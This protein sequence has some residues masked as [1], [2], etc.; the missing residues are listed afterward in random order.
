MPYVYV[1]S[2]KVEVTKN[3]YGVLKRLRYSD[4]P[5]TLWVDALCINQADTTEKS[6]QVLLMSEIY[7]STW[8]CLI[9]LG[10]EPETPVST[11]TQAQSQKVE[12]IIAET[13]LFLQNLMASLSTLDTSS[14]L[15]GDLQAISGSPAT[16][17]KEDTF[18]IGKTRPTIWHG[19]QRDQ[20][21]LEMRTLPST[22]DDSIFQ[23]SCMFRLL[24][25]DLHPCEIPY[26]RLE[27]DDK[28][29]YLTNARRAAHWLVSRDWWTRVWTVQECVLPQESIVI[30]G[31]VEMPWSTLLAAVSNFQRH[32]AG[33]CSS[34][35]GV[36]DMLNLHLDLLPV[37]QDLRARRSTGQAILLEE[38]VREFRYRAA[39]NP[40][41]KVF[42]LLPLV[43][44]WGGNTPLA[45]DYSQG[46]S[47]SQVYGQAIL[48]MVEASGSLAPLC[49]Q[50]GPSRTA[51]VAMP[52]WVPDLSEAYSHGGTLDHF[53]HQLPLYDSS[54]G[55]KASARV[56]DATVLVLEGVRADSIRRASTHVLDRR[57]EGQVS[58]FE[59]WHDV[60]EEE[61]GQTDGN[62]GDSF[63]R[64]LCGDTV[65]LVTGS[66][67]SAQGKA[68]RRAVEDDKI[69]FNAWCEAHG[70]SKLRQH[71][72]TRG[73][74]LDVGLEETGGMNQA[75]TATTRDR[76]FIISKSG[77]MGIAPKMALLTSPAADQIFV[78]LGSN[79]PLVLRPVGSRSISGVGERLC[80][81]LIGDCY[82][83]GIMD[84]EA[85]HDFETKKETLYIV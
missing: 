54:N 53:V 48:K 64:T 2:Q 41:D 62:W 37:L 16:K 27:P 65:G 8:R 42:A 67:V 51:S 25:E 44:D 7:S 47:L 33:C 81:E 32:R 75:I 34:S 36:H 15:M 31:P 63:W 13:D 19:D 46:I 71:N 30:Y 1:D 28:H 77:R 59:H 17:P 78:V 10:D 72:A 11:V 82:L 12:R 45:P 84:G 3:L 74:A 18:K 73:N 56:V 43:T 80:Y 57:H 21:T 5:R 24:A 52:S 66:H 49:Q 58:I 22:Q 85:M 29:T 55:S 69:V 70:H 23:A 4:R 60:A 68:L 79:A 35:E 39:T 83:H 26:F 61:C 20:Q 38:L 9:W 6:S 50:T 40:R 76:R 14:S